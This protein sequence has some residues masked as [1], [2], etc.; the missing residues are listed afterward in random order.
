MRRA[1]LAAQGRVGAVGFCCWLLLLALAQH[2]VP[3]ATLRQRLPKVC[4]A[5]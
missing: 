3:G 4:S 2:T 5:R 1:A